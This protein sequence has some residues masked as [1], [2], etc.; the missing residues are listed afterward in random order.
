MVKL[1]IS[2]FFLLLFS[3]SSVAVQI[4]WAKDRHGN[5]IA[6]D[7]ANKEDGPFSCFE[8][9]KELIVRRG[10]ILAAHFA[11]KHDDDNT[12]PGGLETWQ[13][14]RAKKL[15]SEHL[16]KWQFVVQCKDC[17][18]QKRAL[19]YSA[20]QGHKGRIEYPFGG[21]SV[22]VMV[23]QNNTAVAALEVKFSHAVE[24]E[25][26]Q[27]FK[28]HRIPLLEVKATQVIEAY[29][30]GSF[31]AN[32][33][34]CERCQTCESK[35][36]RPCV[37][38]NKWQSKD[39]LAEIDA[40][41]GHRF[42]TAFVCQKCQE[43]CPFCRKFST[44]K[45]ISANTRCT[46]CIK[47]TTKWHQDL[48]KAITNKN[49]KRLRELI[50]SAPDDVDT[51]DVQQKY[52]TIRQEIEEQERVRLERETE[53]IIQ[54][55]RAA[56]EQWRS[57]VDRAIVEHDCAKMRA[58]LE[59]I[60]KNAESDERKQLKNELAHEEP[61]WQKRLEERA[62][63]IV[64]TNRVPLTV[65]FSEKQYVE[66]YRATWYGGD[67]YSVAAT[68]IKTCSKWLKESQELVPLV[69]KLLKEQPKKKAPA[70]RRQNTKDLPDSKKRCITD[71]FGAKN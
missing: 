15:L 58:L 52:E 40:P 18:N 5:D 16:D 51:T 60:P 20:A 32:I 3:E 33:L 31:K 42:T 12:C 10:A 69:Q 41:I 38:C 57:Q 39:V 63:E 11:H 48:Q 9:S 27:F 17:H 13:H 45:Q 6:A 67:S 30:N 28:T 29:E 64:A 1:I 71:F 62:A 8:C 23:V 25:K 46:S 53:L 54:R 66:Q 56:L 36:R 47:E 65:P 37:Q 21:F 26:K 19:S 4:P 2:L 35:N 50:E 34:G 55:Q 49:L 22:D 70:K 43:L 59:I 61:H 7:S 24:E 68:H 14:I 44:K